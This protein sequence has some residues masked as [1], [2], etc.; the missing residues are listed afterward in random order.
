[1]PSNTIHLLS[2]QASRRKY[3][4]LDTAADTVTDLVNLQRLRDGW[5]DAMRPFLILF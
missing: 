1:L 4:I 5:P 3:P 2:L